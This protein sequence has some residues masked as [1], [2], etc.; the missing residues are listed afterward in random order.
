[1][2]LRKLNTFKRQPNK[3]FPFC[4]SHLMTRGSGRSS[5]ADCAHVCCWEHQPRG[6]G[7]H[8][9]RAADRRDVGDFSGMSTPQKNVSTCGEY[10][11]KV[12]PLRASPK[13]TENQEV[14]YFFFHGRPALK[15][16]QKKT[17]TAAAT[18]V[19]PAGGLRRGRS[20][21]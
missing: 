8:N 19:T 4:E 15:K 9:E 3:S 18:A 20:D 12:E 17:Q 5:A 7:L 10:I 1:M 11:W 21:F 13:K 14:R 6:L 16:K 2:I